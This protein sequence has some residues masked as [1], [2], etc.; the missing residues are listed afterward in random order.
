MSSSKAPARGRPRAF[1]E[2][3]FLDTAIALFS[4]TGFAGISLSTL[5]SASKLTVGSIYKAYGDKAGVFASALERYIALREADLEQRLTPLSN[6]RDRIATLLEYYLNL[7]QGHDG[8]LGCM[9]VTGVTEI[10]QVG[11]AAAILRHQLTSRRQVL[12]RLVSEGHQDGSIARHVECETTADL[13]LALFQGMRVVGR[14]GDLTHDNTAFVN[15]AL[16]LLE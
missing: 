15:Q 3:R 5:T 6:A 10:E 7:S 11:D 13:L 9:V 14:A 1:D 8:R 12:S 2:D 16:R 4:H